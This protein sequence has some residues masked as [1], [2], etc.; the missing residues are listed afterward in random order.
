MDKYVKA[1][2]ALTIL[3]LMSITSVYASVIVWRW[4]TKI[5]VKEPF[6]IT[7]TLPTEATLYPGNYSYTISVT[8][9]ASMDFNATLLWTVTPTNCT[10]TITPLSGTSYKV[11]AMSTVTIPVTISITLNTGATNGTAII[12]WAIERV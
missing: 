5:T 9:H 2:T 1:L 3:T 10:V 7:T 4:T 6:E 8:N 11:P 12:E